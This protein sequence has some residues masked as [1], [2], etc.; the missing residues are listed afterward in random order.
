MEGRIEG[1]KSADGAA[2]EIVQYDKVLRSIPID[3][4]RADPKLGI[5]IKR[6]R[7]EAVE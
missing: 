5:A 3:D 6:N 1:R 2:Y 7:W 4:A